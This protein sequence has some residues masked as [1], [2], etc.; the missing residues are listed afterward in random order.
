MR[1]VFTSC[2]IWKKNKFNKSQEIKNSKSSLGFSLLVSSHCIETIGLT[3]DHRLSLHYTV[4]F[5]E[6]LISGLLASVALTTGLNSP[7][8]SAFLQP[9]HSMTAA[10][11]TPT[12]TLIF[13]THKVSRNATEIQANL[14]SKTQ[15]P[16]DKKKKPV[17]ITRTTS[18]WNWIKV[19]LH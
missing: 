10:A 12:G 6:S 19:Q 1:K 9:K 18:R 8:E 15:N 16:E 11:V 3:N 4:F 7:A 13:W 2:F 17:Y 5:W 14:I